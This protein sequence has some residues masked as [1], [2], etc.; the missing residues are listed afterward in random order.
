[1]TEEEIRSKIT[2]D[3]VDIRQILESGATIQE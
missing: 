2:V 1:M 3:D